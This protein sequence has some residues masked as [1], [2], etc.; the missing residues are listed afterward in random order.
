MP[1]ADVLDLSELEVW[2]KV[3]ELDRANLK[4]GQEA[5][6]QL[7]AIPDKRFSGKIKAMSGTATSDVF[8]CD[9]S[10]KFDIIFAIDMKQLLTGIGMKQSDIDRI[11]ATAEANAKKDTNR[12]ADPFA[13]AAA[14]AAAAKAAEAGQVA[15]DQGGGRGRRGGG[16]GGNRQRGDAGQGGAGGGRGGDNA[17]RGGDNAGR[18][19]DNAG[20]G[21]PGG[22][23]RFGNMSPEDRQ[24]MTELRQK[25]QGASDTDREK[26]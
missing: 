10:K 17:G 1:V 9:P 24:K 5:L 14:A 25:M 16:G 18:G 19:G 2:A 11:M 26:Q 21:G 3:G 6:L 12:N 7:D 13:A 20:R 22:G 23:G 4:E 8:S 15:D